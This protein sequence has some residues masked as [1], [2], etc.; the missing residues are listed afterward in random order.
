MDDL[1]MS[2]QLARISTANSYE[3]IFCDNIEEIAKQKDAIVLVIDLNLVSYKHL[4]RIACIF[5]DR[6]INLIGYCRKLDSILVNY[7]IKL[8]CDMVIK[9]NDLIRNLGSILAKI[10]NVCRVPI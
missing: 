3:L 2:A 6:N 8:G 7:F 10:I 1:Q 4:Q 9:R 5:Q